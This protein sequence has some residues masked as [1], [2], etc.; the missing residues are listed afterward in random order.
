M[1]KAWFKILLA[2]IAA[3]AVCAALFGCADD[4][5]KSD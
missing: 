3:I 5:E 2:A 1:K 4:K